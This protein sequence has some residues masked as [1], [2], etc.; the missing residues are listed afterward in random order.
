MSFSFSGQLLPQL[1]QHITYVQYLG[2]AFAIWGGMPVLNS[3]PTLAFL[4]KIDN[5]DPYETE[6]GNF[7]RT[8]SMQWYEYPRLALGTHTVNVSEMLPGQG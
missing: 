4:V 6:V 5:N 1:K 7:D 2:R 3:F 8:R